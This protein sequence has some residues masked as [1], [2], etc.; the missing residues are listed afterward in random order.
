[1]KTAILLVLSLL[2]SGCAHMP[3][4]A[5]RLNKYYDSTVIVKVSGPLGRWSGTGFSIANDSGDTVGS[6]ILTNKHVCAV[7]DAAAY[8]LTDHNGNKVSASFVRVADHADLCLLHTD[9]VLSPV[10]L[11]KHDA[12]RAE[13]IVVV[14]A[15]HG[16]YP[17]FTEGFVSGYCPVD[18]AG[19][20]FE[21][22]LR[23]ECTSVPIYPGNSGSPAFNDAGECVGIMFAG[24]NDAEHMTAMVPV[25]LIHRFL[26]QSND[27]FER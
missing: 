25:E 8:T 21:V 12:K 19:P 27:M 26:D 23:A 5:S 16:V 4:T 2:I 6:T 17:N 24:R 13:H 18:I 20:N 14:G 9:A 15:P 22:H 7:G 10:K 3:P 11:A 1:M